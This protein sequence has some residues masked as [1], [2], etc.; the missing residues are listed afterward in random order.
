MDDLPRQKRLKNIRRIIPAVEIER[1]KVPRFPTHI[2]IR[3]LE[4]R[5]QRLEAAADIEDEGQRLVLLR[6]LQ[7]KIAEIRLSL[8]GLRE[9]AV[10]PCQPRDLL[11]NRWVYIRHSNSGALGGR[12]CLERVS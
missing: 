7:Q 1:L 8:P 2:E 3:A 4:Y 12:Y 11:A 6:V 5:R 9:M 10:F